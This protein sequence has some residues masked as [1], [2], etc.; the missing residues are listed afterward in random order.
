MVDNLS[1]EARS[2]N[3][4]QIR[5]K[6]SKPELAVR[7]VLHQ[8]GFRFRIHRRDLPGSPDIVMSKYKVA[9]FVNGCF[10]HGHNNCKKATIPKTNISFWQKKIEMNKKRDEKVQCD[11][12]E[13]GWKISTIW[14]CEIILYKENLAQLL[15]RK[16]TTFI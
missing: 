13:I 11:L 10:W 16:L 5:S 2:E 1:K 6:N 12:N 7:S 9:I 4:R 3:M 15:S 8:M 14:E